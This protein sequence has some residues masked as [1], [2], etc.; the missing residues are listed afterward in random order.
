V[1]VRK[2]RIQRPAPWRPVLPVSSGRGWGAVGP[3][4]RR[5]LLLLLVLVLVLVLV[6]LT[7]PTPIGKV[8]HLRCRRVSAPT[9]S[10][11]RTSASQSPDPLTVRRDSASD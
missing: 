10:W 1:P 9:A 8:I 2:V 4:R 11:V 7:P 6:Y 3:G 5:P